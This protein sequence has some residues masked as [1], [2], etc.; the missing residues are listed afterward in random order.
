MSLNVNQSMKYST[1]Q[2][3]NGLVP[4]EGPR[5]IPIPLD[6]SVN[7]SQAFDFYPQSSLSYL[8][9]VQCIFADNADND[10]PMIIVWNGTQQRTIIPPGFMGYLPVLVLSPYKFVVTCNGGTTAQLILLNVPMPAFIWPTTQTTPLFDGS[11]N[12]LVS[13]AALEALISG[14]YLQVTPGVRGNNDIIRPDFKADLLLTGNAIT[15]AVVTET[16]ITGAPG[17]FMNAF[18]LRMSGDATLAAPGI[19][20]V[21]LEDDGVEIAGVDIFLPAVPIT[22]LPM[23]PILKQSGLNYLS[24]GNATDLAVTIDVALATGSLSWVIAAGVTAIIR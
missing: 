4:P 23:I 8:S 5:A 24:D 7:V 13:D 20:H 14:G 12:L 2:I 16:V 19:V 11:G 22:N 10:V 9:Y 3:F 1:Q 21:A 17:F 15:A 18:D 6:F